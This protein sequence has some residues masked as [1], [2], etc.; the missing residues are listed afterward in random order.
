MIRVRRAALWAVISF[1]I[2]ATGQV[3]RAQA[4]LPTVSQTIPPLSLSTATGGT[5]SLD[6]KNYFAVSNVTGTVVQYNTDLGKFNVELFASDAPLSVANFLRYVAANSYTNTIIHRTAALGGGTANGIVQ[7]GGYT[8]ALPPV[9]VS[10]SSP[11]ALEYKLANARGTLAMA[12][13]SELNSATS[14]WFFNTDDNTTVLGPTNGGGYAV[15]GRVLGTGM[16]VVDAIFSTPRYNVGSPFDNLPLRNVVSGQTDVQLVNL[17]KVASITT[18]PIY[19]TDGVAGVLSF[20]VSSSDESIARGAMANSLLTITPIAGGS[21]TIT[22]RATDTNG[23]AT[24]ATFVVTVSGAATK[25]VISAQPVAQTVASGSTVVFNV[26]ATGSP[27]YQWKRNGADVTNG[28]S[29]TLVITGATAAD[30][31]DYTVEVKNSAGSDISSVATLSINNATATEVGRLVNLSILTTAGTGAKVLT[32]GASVGPLTSN[33][34]LPLIVRGVGPGLRDFFGITTALADPTMTVFDGKSNKIGENDNWSSGGA[35][36]LAAA[37][38]SV[39]AFPLSAGSLD[40]AFASLTPGFAVGGYSVQ[41]TGK[42]TASGTVIAEIYDASGSAR[43]A[44]TPRLV[45]LATLAQVDAN[46]DLRV[47]FVLR[48]L[49]ARTVLIRGVGPSLAQLGVTGVMADPKLELFDNDHG[50]VK[51]GENDNWGGAA[52]IDAVSKSVGAFDL[53]GA[54]TKD[55]VILVTL[56]SG[57]YSARLSGANGTSGVA[58][59]EVYEVP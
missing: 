22:V 31:G 21:A 57:A 23:N 26:T 4:T 52:Q 41:V 10:K 39:G 59:V 40:S 42:G 25:P 3:L 18:V 6:L 56:P 1:V 15:F 12:R 35:T 51:L 44:T 9:A 34:K 53:S 13:T 11:I 29:A 27:T 55:A 14:E 17:V 24:T 20:S 37:F 50:G 19:P 8:Y 43:T 45:N 7:G 38:N 58:I 16:T 30:A 36:E 28:T 54:A 49:S 47:G 48:G 32:V 33:E 2:I 5:A 46:G